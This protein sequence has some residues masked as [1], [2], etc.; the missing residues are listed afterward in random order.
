MNCDLLRPTPPTQ[1]PQNFPQAILSYFSPTRL[2][3]FW[4]N[5]WEH[6]AMWFSGHTRAEPFEGLVS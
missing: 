6:L 2:R 5:E 4:Q 1:R 3:M